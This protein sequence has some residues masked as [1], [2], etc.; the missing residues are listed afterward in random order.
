MNKDIFPCIWFNNNGKEAADFYVETFK[1]EIV[2]TSPMVLSLELFGQKLMILN[3][4]SAFEINA[5]ISF[6]VFCETENEVEKYWKNLSQ[7]GIIL[8]DLGEYPWSKKYGWVRDKFGVTW[9]LYLGESNGDQKIIPTLMFIHENNGKAFE[10]MGF[11]TNIFPNSNKGNV[12]KY[13]DGLGNT[14]NEIPNNVQ[15]EDFSLNGMHFQAMD[16]SYDHKFDFNESISIVV[17]TE[18]QKETDF[19]W[20]SLISDGGIESQCGWLK[21]KYGISW[22]ITPK[23]LMKLT[24]DSD[25]EKAGKVF[26]TM[27]KM[28]KIIISDL[29]AAYNS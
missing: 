27:M 19:Y 11:Y 17:M 10:A 28:K 24:T 29:E 3:V 1:G 12:L 6:M 16:N 14:S 20:N 5:S 18:D 26:Q 23:K 22:Q 9:Q 13:G 25:R 4:D 7:N 21:D 8:M 15:M 2:G